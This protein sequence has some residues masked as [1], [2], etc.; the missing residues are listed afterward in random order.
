M[1]REGAVD[2][3]VCSFVQVMGESAGPLWH[4]GTRRR[5]ERFEFV[6]LSGLEAREEGGRE[7]WRVEER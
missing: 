1:G 7:G 4:W 3:F 2:E 6:Y 5:G